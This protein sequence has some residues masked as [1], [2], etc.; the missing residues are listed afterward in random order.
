MN[1]TEIKHWTVVGR[2]AETI[3]ELFDWPDPG[4]NGIE[5]KLKIG[6]YAEFE[7]DDPAAYVLGHVLGH[8]SDLLTALEDDI[9]HL[10][11]D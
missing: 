6:G 11:G 1:E 7:D 8:L 9:N 3:R 4:E 5:P 10:K 2:A